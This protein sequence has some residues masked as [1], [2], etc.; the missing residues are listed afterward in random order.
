[1]GRGAER[2]GGSKE[3]RGHYLGALRGFQ[4]ATHD[5]SPRRGPGQISCRPEPG[6]LCTACDN[7]LRSLKNPKA[8]QTVSEN[9]VPLVLTGCLGLHLSCSLPLPHPGFRVDSQSPI[10]AH[11]ACPGAGKGPVG[12]LPV[13]NSCSSLIFVQLLFLHSSL[14]CWEPTSRD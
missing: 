14:R 3:S 10:Q 1:M 13:W 5:H 6:G 9:Q 4:A 8:S 11:R 2:N 7:W 12:L